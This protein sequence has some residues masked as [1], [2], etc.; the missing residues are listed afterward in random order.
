M[1]YDN[2]ERFKYT[3]M[4]DCVLPKQ[5]GGMQRLKRGDEVTG[6]HYE[7]FLKTGVLQRNEGAGTKAADV[8][9][10]KPLKAEKADVP[11][12]EKKKEEKPKETEEEV[13]TR[14]GLE[15]MTKRELVEL[16][17]PEWN[18]TKADLID[19]L[20]EDQEDRGE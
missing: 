19:M 1:G 7:R 16:Y 6:P 12:P 20:L 11:A 14:E 4:Q 10:S 15:A 9:P 5:H 17:E 2:A 3:V 8:V 18:G 13:L